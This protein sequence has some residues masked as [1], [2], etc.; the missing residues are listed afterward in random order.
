MTA[1]LALTEDLI[2]RRSVTPA[3]EG[4]QAI[5]ETRLKALGFDCEALVSGPDDFRV[6]NLWAVRRGTQGKDG[7]LLVFAGHTDVVPTGPLEQWHSDPF[8]P[9]HRDGKL[10]GRGAADMK[11]SIAGF[12]VA[13]EEF[14]KA[15]PAHA[16]SI[17][18]LITSDEEGP[19]HDGTIKV[20]EAL[21]AR[22]ERLDYC[23]IGEPTSVDTLGDMVKNGR[24][25]SLS[26]KLTVKGIQCHIAYP[27]L[28]R[29][30]I[31]EAAPALAELAAEV[32]D[33]GN[34]YFPPTSWQMSNIHGGTGATNVIPGHV[35]IDFNF[36][37]S[38]ASTP[39]G[40]KARVHAILDRH[41]LEY[42]LDW[43]LGGE[44]F[45]TPRGELSDALSS[46]IE[47]E[48]GV[49]T[50]LSTTGGTS[51]G[52]FIAKI[53]PQVIEFGP[54]NASIHKIDEHVEVR[55]IEPLKNVYRGVLE[56]LVA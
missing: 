51:D 48:T 28:G 55:F 10:Y 35:T 38:T 49:K 19:A 31:H 25:G 14:V 1:T 2:R 21:S 5:L 34:E 17:A 9:T 18:F 8:A 3:D 44:P 36:R 39:E 37:F 12:V 41:Q 16:G 33:Q 32:W 43:T 40:L 23:V 42:A 27:H 24:R 52:R 30:P 13:V 7:K 6:T 54:P 53:C 11:T 50:E 47:A 29:N 46:A 22:G 20:V 26:G 4:C 56:R 15:H 45:L